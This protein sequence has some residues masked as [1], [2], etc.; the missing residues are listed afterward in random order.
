MSDHKKRS[1]PLAVTIT[2]VRRRRK[3]KKGD[4]A[5]GDRRYR[6][7]ILVLTAAL[8]LMGGGA[9]LLHWLAA[10]PPLVKATAVSRRPVDSTLEGKRPPVVKEQAPAPAE[11]VRVKQEDRA[12]AGQK[13]A[14]TGD[15]LK[16]LMASARRQEKNGDL[17][18]ALA[19][20]RQAVKIDP[21][22]HQPR[23]ELQRVQH[24]L[25]EQRFEQLMS[26]GLAAMHAADYR[27]ARSKLVQAQKIKPTS[28]EA[29]DALF[30]VDQALR[31]ER[32]EKLGRQA[33]TAEQ[34]E[35]WPR[36]LKA[37]LAVLE[38]D[39]SIEFAI[40][41]KARALEQQRLFERLEFFLAN[42]QVL[43]SDSQLRHAVLLL[44]E[45]EAATG[46]GPK[47]NARLARLQQLVKAA[48][49]PV[50][51]VIE[52]DNLTEV[53]VYRVGKL[54]RFAVHELQLRPGTYT[55][56]GSRDGYQDVRRK[57]LVKAG[58][59]VVRISIACRVKI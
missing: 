1:R 4:P 17:V 50:R 32:I 58:Q 20:Y 38:T 11:P 36:A 53:A 37:Y 24:L 46:R 8:L 39:A 55:V 21:D 47:L 10:K 22:A 13:P 48:Q 19:S 26:G 49:T 56:V 25:A 33:R 23:R 54:G 18:A 15:P 34:A 29:A 57:I 28:R 16:R 5:A 45:A 42:P 40:R 35:D 12:K 14:E 31:L 3:I 59:P 44:G 27:A 7:I 6:F 9:W 43:E 52:S 30:E 51:V 2:P 41:G